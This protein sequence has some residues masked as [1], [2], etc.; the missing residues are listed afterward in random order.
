MRLPLAIIS[1]TKFAC[2]ALNTGARAT[3]NANALTTSLLLCSVPYRPDSL[4]PLVSTCG[5]TNQRSREGGRKSRVVGQPAA[6]FYCG[7]LLY[8]ATCYGV[9][10]IAVGHSPTK[11]F[12]YRIFT[13]RF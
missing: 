4:C 6:V 10:V 5:S 1:A 9:C 3:P 7:C 11:S 8:P 2:C 13:R 12:L